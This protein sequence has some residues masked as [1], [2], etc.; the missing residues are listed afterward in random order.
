MKVVGPVNDWLPANV[1]FEAVAVAVM[2]PADVMLPPPDID[3]PDPVKLAIEVVALPVVPR[4]PAF[5]KEFVLIFIA[6][7]VT[8]ATMDEALSRLT[9]LPVKVTGL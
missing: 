3:S 5:I 1:R 7:C 2:P 9:V 4:E 8:L 6:A